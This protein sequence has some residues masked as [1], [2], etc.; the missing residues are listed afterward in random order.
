M[1]VYVITTSIIWPLWLRYFYALLKQIP[2]FLG[3]VI[4]VVNVLTPLAAI[5]G[6]WLLGKYGA[7]RALKLFL[8][9]VVFLV[10]IA[11]TIWVSYKFRTQV[12]EEAKSRSEEA[13]QLANTEFQ[14]TRDSRDSK[15]NDVRTTALINMDQAIAKITS[16]L[17]IVVYYRFPEAHLRSISIHLLRPVEPGKQSYEVLNL[18]QEGREK[19]DSAALPLSDS[20]IGYSMQ[21]DRTAY[22]PDV[23]LRESQFPVCSKFK[24]VSDAVPSYASLLCVPLG[25]ASVEA[26]K[27]AGICFDSVNAHAFDDQ[28]SS[29]IDA[30]APQL[31]HLSSLLNDFRELMSQELSAPRD[32]RLAL[33]WLP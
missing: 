17:Y 19:K 31:N 18:V 3:P 22:C 30:L 4:W 33:S 1:P 13:Y 7:A 23:R 27:S 16:E 11:T 9:V 10:S 28:E 5:V 25:G 26:K 20:F 2:Q 29:L 24:G 6:V 14:A 32:E 21:E 15:V 8:A 12:A